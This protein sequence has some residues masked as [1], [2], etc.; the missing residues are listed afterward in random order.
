MK[1]TVDTNWIGNMAFESIIDDYKVK[2]DAA[3]ESGGTMQGP[4]PKPLVLGALAGCTGMDVISILKKKQ[5][6]PD[7]FKISITGDL[8]EDHPKYYK[9]I[10]IVFEVHGKGFENN[11]DLLPK[12][13]RAIQLST[14]NYCGVNAMLKN[15]C[16][17]THEIILKN[18]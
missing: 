3:P 1:E 15:S 17:I 14:D 2:L 5:V 7:K 16:E 10:H 9:Y 18:S 8:T 6:I 4:R 13:Q 12:V 11:A